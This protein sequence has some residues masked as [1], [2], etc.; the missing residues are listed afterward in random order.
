[1]L[2]DESMNGV[3]GRKCALVID[4]SPIQLRALND[5]LKE[6][7]DVMMA[8]SGM[9]ALTLIGKRIPDIIFLDYDMPVCDGKM[10]LQMIRELEETKDIPVVFLTGIGDKE[11]IQAVLALRPAGYLLKPA[12]ASKIYEFVDKYLG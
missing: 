2:S 12:N 7:C 1:M 9:K 10:T 8:T 6:K 4:D 11:H 3:S 5:M